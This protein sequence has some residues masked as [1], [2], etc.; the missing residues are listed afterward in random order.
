ME[1]GKGHRGLKNPFHLGQCT[2]GSVRHH[3]NNHNSG[4][5]TDLT[6]RSEYTRRVSPC[7]KYSLQ[8]SLTYVK[9]L[10]TAKH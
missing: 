3:G 5:H 2:S 1:P 10:P 9:I 4:A 8:K 6:A 7:G